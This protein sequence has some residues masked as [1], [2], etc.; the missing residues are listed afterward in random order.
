M[1]WYSATE[2]ARSLIAA[3]ATIIGL[4]EDGQL[5]AVNIA[6]VSSVRKR[7]RISEAM[8]SMF[9]EKRASRAAILSAD[10][11]PEHLN[12]QSTTSSLAVTGGGE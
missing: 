3:P 7:W 11:S 10:I 12:S 8:L 1:K 6:R 4:I 9:K 5:E 2:V